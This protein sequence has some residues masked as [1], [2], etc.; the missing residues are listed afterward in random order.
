M[1]SQRAIDVMRTFISLC[2]SCALALV[3]SS[4]IAEKEFVDGIDWT[5]YVTE[6]VATI[7]SGSSPAIVRETSGVVT[8]PD[9]LGGC[10]VEHIDKLAFYGCSGI[11]QVKIPKSIQTIGSLAFGDCFGLEIVELQDGLVTIASSAF[12]SC[13]GLREITVPKSVESI[14][15]NAFS[16]CFGLKNISIPFVGSE[17]GIEYVYGRFID[18]FPMSFDGP[19]H[20]TITDDVA[21]ENQSFYAIESLESVVIDCELKSIGDNAFE[22]CGG[23][24]SISIPASVESIGAF[25]FNGCTNLGAGIVVSGGCVLTV[26][27]EC[28]EEVRLAPGIRMVAG[29]AFCGCKT[30]ERVFVPEGVVSIGRSAFS[31]C[32]SLVQIEL[33]ET[34]ESLGDYAFENIG[35]D[36]VTIPGRLKHVPLNAFAE[37]KALQ[38]VIISSGVESI[39]ESA[40][41]KCENLVSVDLPESL[42]EIGSRSFEGCVKLSDIVI[43]ARA[44]KLGA[45]AFSGCK[46]LLDARVPEGVEVV[47]EGLF[48]ECRGLTNLHIAS[49]VREIEHGSFYGCSS[50]EK[51]VFPQGLRKIGPWSC[52]WCRNIHEIAFGDELSAIGD[53]A[54]YGCERLGGVDF[55]YTVDTIG[56][57]AFSGCLDLPIIS[58]HAGVTNI[59]ACAFSYCSSLK[60]FDVD[61]SNQGY[62]SVGGVLYSKDRKRL[63]VCPGGAEDPVIADGVERIE[64]YSFAQCYGLHGI[65]VPASVS[66][67]CA[68]AFV[69]CYYLTNA[70]FTGDAPAVGESAF[71]GVSPTFRFEAYVDSKGWPTDGQWQGHPLVL[72]DRETALKHKVSFDADGGT[73]SPEA[74]MRRE[75]EPIGELPTV[76]KYGYEFMG[77]HSNSVEGVQFCDATIMPS[78]DLLL[79][80]AWERKPYTITFESG[81]GLPIAPIVRLY[82]DPIGELPTIESPDRHFVGWFADPEGMDEQ[83]KADMLV[84][85]CM[86][87]YAGWARSCV[88]DGREWVYDDVA[89]SV[90]IHSMQIDGDVSVPEA[91]DGL[92][93]REIPDACF[94]NCSNLT[95][96]TLP[97]SVTNIGAYAFYNCVNLRNVEFGLG[98]VS[99]RSGAFANCT[100]LQGISMPSSMRTLGD[101]LAVTNGVNTQVFRSDFEFETN[102]VEEFEFSVSRRHERT[103]LQN[104]SMGNNGMGVFEGCTNLSFAILN[105][106]LQRIGAG[107]FR[108]CSALVELTVPDGVMEI[109]GMRESFASYDYTSTQFYEDEYAVKGQEPSRLSSDSMRVLLNRNLKHEGSGFLQGCTSLAQVILPKEMDYLGPYSFAGCTRLKAVELPENLE[110]ICEGTFSGCKG[111]QHVMMGNLVEVIGAAELPCQ[112]STCYSFDFW[113]QNGCAPSVLTQDCVHKTANGHWVDSVSENGSEPSVIEGDEGDRRWLPDPQGVR[114]AVDDGAFWDWFYRWRGTEVVMSAGCSLSDDMLN[115]LRREFV[116][117]RP[118]GPSFESSGA[119]V[120]YGCSSLCEVRLPQSVRR[121]ADYSFYDCCNLVK[122]ELP[123]ELGMLGYQVFG[124]ETALMDIAT[125]WFNFS[126]LWEIFPSHSY[127]T[128]LVILSSPPDIMDPND[129]VPSVMKEMRGERLTIEEL[130]ARGGT[131]TANESQEIARK[132]MEDLWITQDEVLYG[133]RNLKSLTL[134]EGLRSFDWTIGWWSTQKLLDVTLPNTLVGLGLRALAGFPVEHIV[135]PSSLQRMEDE[136]FLESNVAEVMFMGNA[137]CDVSPNVFVETTGWDPDYAAREDLVVSVYPGTTGWDG[138]AESAALPTDGLW[139][140]HAA[141]YKRRPIQ[142]VRQPVSAALGGEGGADALTYFDATLDRLVTVPQTWL[143]SYG[144]LSVD[145]AGAASM[146][147]ISPIAS[148]SLYDS[149]VA[150]LD[151]TDEKSQFKVKI[152]I[153]NNEPV[154]TW[155]PELTPEEAALRKYTTYGCTELGGKWYNADEAPAELKSQLRFFKVGVEMK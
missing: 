105:H 23:L 90:R 135:I 72:L 110:A 47:P 115:N 55:P 18:I 6:G 103:A 116:S 35:I 143:N 64:V 83:V 112:I 93:V 146:S 42:V 9:V 70:L 37:C 5:Y 40:F 151:P 130:M 121:I 154:I 131:M 76:E 62:T 44:T 17:R 132:C 73:P 126:S 10:P 95:S 120:F 79:V 52:A 139:P 49:S 53:Y 104:V 122:I 140:A 39:G 26:N 7:G 14:G 27:G 29:G 128:N 12:S 155:E 127:V 75:G 74:L 65:V 34:L 69:S 117:V 20:L 22:Y 108:G 50:L 148:R 30:L 88:V 21:I 48:W 124:G 133:F 13:C 1:D 92:P 100:L 19:I 11:T 84:E 54:F 98:L 147:S 153:V 71:E 43:S 4:A 99:I 66:N 28:P 114:F 123:K 8:I 38:H 67:I 41:A 61:S 46:G 119:G 137:P 78:D 150:G 59:G 63:I 107:V 45:Y 102:I 2:L 36:A 3:A 144:L 16:G 68:S 56:A 152:E 51:I 85:G 145:A 96:V 60:G 91:L 31:W 15:S 77:W 82:Q 129:V 32:P 57:Y 97:T 89:G 101:W 86:T 81:V 149:Y 111:L 87:L 118:M 136:V 94:A 109:G 58:I 25:A 142:F 141:V 80:A 33:P 125:P 138:E 134:P 113:T 106:G 24:K